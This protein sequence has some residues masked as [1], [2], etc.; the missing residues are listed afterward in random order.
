MYNIGLYCIIKNEYRLYEFLLYYLH[1]G[2]NYFF[3]LDDDS[4]IDY[5]DIFKKL[6]IDNNCYEIHK[7]KDL[8]VEI[9]EY[10]FQHEF[11]S[12]YFF[13]SYLYDRLLTKKID[14]IMQID[15]DE[16]LCFKEQS[17]TDIIEKY[18]PF[19][20]IRINWLI[21]GSN[22]IINNNS[23]SIIKTFIYCS[24]KL[25]EL[26]KSITK[27]SSIDKSKFKYGISAHYTPIYDSCI[28][29]NILNQIIDNR[30]VSIKLD[31]SYENIL[32]NV[33][34][35]HYVNQ[36]FNTFVKRKILRIDTFKHLC[37]VNK[38]KVYIYNNLDDFILF[39]Y[40]KYINEIDCILEEKFKIIPNEYINFLISFYNC[41]NLNDHINLNVMNKLYNK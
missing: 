21:F 19:D 12:S 8:Q 10:T 1:L 32:K 35:A 31:L 6:D 40:K 33:Y 30:S 5:Y 37:D 28:T 39:V 13:S 11:K 20:A 23:D 26:T 22:N 38:T 18:Q 16:F 27:V 41:H 7:T 14:Y 24:E 2:I 4:N 9:T 15:A 34:L 17:I 29:K 36:D 3:I 25:Q